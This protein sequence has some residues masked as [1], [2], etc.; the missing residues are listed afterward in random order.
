MDGIREYTFEPKKLTS[1]QRLSLAKKVFKNAHKE[2][3]NGVTFREFYY[4]VFI[5]PTVQTKIRIYILKNN[6]IGYST[7]QLYKIKKSK[8]HC[9]VIMTEVCSKETAHHI[10]PIHF[11]VKEAAK[12]IF[13]NPFAIVFMVDTLMSPIIYKKL[14]H[15]AFEIYPVYNKEVPS[16]LTKLCRIMAKIFHWN[17]KSYGKYII[18]RLSWRVKNKYVLQD[19][20]FDPNKEYFSSI[21]PDF[22]LGKGLVIIIPVTL[23]NI[24][25]TLIKT[26]THHYYNKLKKWIV[27]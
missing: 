26:S 20:S 17:F 1:A 25:A 6:V 23:F 15:T 27:L 2:V 12:F 22:E 14:C 13:L 5:P 18:R 3:F 11:F 24:I 16:K 19:K 21:L 10:N 8:L 4:A 9:Y 7:F